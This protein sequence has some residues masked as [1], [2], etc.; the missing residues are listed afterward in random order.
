MLIVATAVLQYRW[1]L[2]IRRAA[3]TGLGASLESVMVQ[4]HLNLYRELSTICIALQ[5]GPDSGAHNHWNDYLLRFEAW[6]RAASGTGVSENI[7]SNP[8]V[9]KNIYIYEASSPVARLLRLDPDA[10]RIGS[11][12]VPPELGPFLTYLQQKSGTLR[13]ALRAWDPE[14]SRQTKPSERDLN[15]LQARTTTG[16]QFEESIPAI[17]H[18]IVHQS[19]E[20]RNRTSQ[21]DWLMVVLN[22]EA[23]TSRIL[24]QLASC[25]FG[26]KNGLEYKLAVV[27]LGKTSQVL[28]SS[29]PV[30]GIR[31]LSESD[32]VMTIFGPP[33]ESTEGSF[34]RIIRSR[35]SLH[36][37]EWRSLSRLREFGQRDEWKGCSPASH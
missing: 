25:Y 29:D 34:W 16:W 33:P 26:G 28:Y 30:F 37:D 32:S 3:E 5:V 24:P 7:Y 8:D 31:D 23:I 20:R 4:W 22:R 1:N 12:A 21:V 18:P 10:N 14:G 13:V 6:R 35:E 19:D 17:V 9:V 36:G 2:Q 11:S 27:T 15:E